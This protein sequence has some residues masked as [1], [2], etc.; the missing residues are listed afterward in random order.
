MMQDDKMINM[1]QN[2]KKKNTPN[3][4]HDSIYQQKR[5]ILLLAHINTYK[6]I[7]KSTGLKHY[8]QSIKLKKKKNTN[9]NTKVMLVH[10]SDKNI[11]EF[12]FQSKKECTIKPT[13]IPCTKS[14]VL[15]WLRVGPL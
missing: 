9:K 8:I 7:P 1:L 14:S 11:L 2:L 3:K 6:F 5:K 12:C 10:L 15:K 4:L 13:E